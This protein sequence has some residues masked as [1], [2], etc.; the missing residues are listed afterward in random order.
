M[1]SVHIFVSQGRF[2]SFEALRKFIDPTY[3]E[4][5]DQID[6]EFVR[7]VGINEFEPMCIEAIHSTAIKPLRLLLK[8]AS[9]SD[10]WLPHFA[11]TCDADSAICVFE[12]NVVLR[13][14][15][16]SLRYY[17]AFFYKP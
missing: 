7:E 17:G 5:G 4:D 10:Q 13:P 6:S 11:V 9:Y 8:R 1:P 2:S 16:T 15:A 14:E 3:T 12:P